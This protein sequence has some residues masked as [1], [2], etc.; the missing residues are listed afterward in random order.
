MNLKYNSRSKSVNANDDIVQNEI[1][2]KVWGFFFM[3]RHRLGDRLRCEGFTNSLIL[4]F[5]YSSYPHQ[6]TRTKHER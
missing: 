1:I 6:R 4:N 3:G 2:D 5:L